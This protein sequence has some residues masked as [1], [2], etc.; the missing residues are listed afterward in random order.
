MTRLRACARNGK[1]NVATLFAL[2]LIPLSI[3]AGGGVDYVHAINAKA[4]LQSRLDDAVLAAGHYPFL[5][6][7]KAKIK[8]T[9]TNYLTA[10]MTGPLQDVTLSGVNVVLDPTKNSMHADVTAKVPLT[11]LRIIGL[12]DF[13]IKITSGAT[14]AIGATEIVLVLDNTGSMNWSLNGGSG[15]KLAELKRTAKKLIDDLYA[16][17]LQSNTAIKVGIV[18]F[19]RAVRVSTSKRNEL[20]LSLNENCMPWMSCY[21]YN[22]QGFVGFRDSPDDITDSNYGL[23]KVPAISLNYNLNTIT[24]LTVLSSSSVQQLKSSIDSMVAGGGT[25]IPE[26]LVWGWRVLSPNKPYTEGASDQEVRNKGL[27]RVIILLTDGLNSCGRDPMNPSMPKC[28]PDPVPSSILDQSNQKILSLCNK[29]KQINPATGRRYAEIAT[30]GLGL[31]S[32]TN[33]FPSYASAVQQIKTTLKS[34]STL[35]YYDVTGQQSTLADAFGKI[36]DRIAKLHLSL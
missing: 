27:N 12:N 13:D 11:F 17:S 30:I 19:S 2:S 26:G 22:W 29:I 34:C 18:P 31:D 3:V 1:G 5:E 16:D 36:S 7:N 33:A 28:Y 15:S 20:W 32:I 25:N 6:S 24:P 21:V 23:H 14:N 4:K 10:R 35:G 9:I 8:A